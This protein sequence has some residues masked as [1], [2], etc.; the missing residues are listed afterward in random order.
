MDAPLNL[1]PARG[2]SVWDRPNNSIDPWQAA[3][4]T[5]GLLLVG[6]GYPYRSRSRQIGAALGLLGLAIGL[7]SQ[8]RRLPAT[9]TSIKRWMVRDAKTEAAV[10]RAIEASFP[11]SDP[12]AH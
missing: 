11:A 12:P 4:V 3:A 8:R 6:S 1:T 2:P 5:A 10:D 7:R 9:V